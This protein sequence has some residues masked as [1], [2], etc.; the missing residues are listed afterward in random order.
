MHVCMPSYMY[1]CMYACVCVCIM[2][3]YICMCVQRRIHA[4]RGNVAMALPS[5][6]A[7]DFDLSPTKKQTWDTREHIK[8]APTS[9]T[10]WIRGPL[11]EYLD[12]LVMCVFCLY[13]YEKEIIFRR[14][15]SVTWANRRVEE[16]RS[17]EDE[18]KNQSSHH[19]R[20]HLIGQDTPR[21]NVTVAILSAF[22]LP[23]S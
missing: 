13:M 2:H 10:V 8:L 11:A 15:I 18:S 22:R 5:S 4:V 16:Y 14:K 7:S 23:E 9:P 12:L 6:L 17:V 3:V 21:A 19:R 1:A 20:Q